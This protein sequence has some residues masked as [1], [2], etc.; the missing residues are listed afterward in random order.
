MHTKRRLAAR[1]HPDPTEELK[2]SPGVTLYISRGWEKRFGLN[3][4]EK[5]EGRKE[6]RGKKEG[7]KAR[8]RREGETA[9]DTEIFRSRRIHPCM[10]VCVRR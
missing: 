7:S 3:E 5:G 8:E 9:A 10:H 2:R 1:L 4:S 6:G